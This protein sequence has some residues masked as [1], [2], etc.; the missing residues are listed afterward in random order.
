MRGRASRL[1]AP[2]RIL[3]SLDAPLPKLTALPPVELKG[4]PEPISVHRV[5][6]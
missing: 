2:G 3:S 6:P 4:I 1:F 5:D